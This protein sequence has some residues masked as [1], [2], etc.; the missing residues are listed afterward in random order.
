MRNLQEEVQ[1]HPSLV[2]IEG[3]TGTEREISNVPT[4]PK[5]LLGTGAVQKRKEGESGGFVDFNVAKRRSQEVM[6][7]EAS[8]EVDQGVKDWIQRKSRFESS[9]PSTIPGSYEMT[10][11]HRLHST[12]WYETSASADTGSQYTN[13]REIDLSSGRQEF[14]SRRYDPLDAPSGNRPIEPTIGDLGQML[15]Q[16]MGLMKNMVQDKT[17]SGVASEAAEQSTRKKFTETFEE[18]YGAMPSMSNP[19]RC[20]PRTSGLRP[21]KGLPGTWDEYQIHFEQIC[22]W[23]NW[24][25]TKAAEALGMSLEE[26]AAVYIH[27]LPGFRGFTIDQLCDKLAD[28]F[29]ANRTVAE[30]RMLLKMRKKQPNETYEH[31]AQDIARLANRVYSQSTYYAEQEARD[32]FLRAL[33]DEISLPIA[34]SNPKTLSDCVAHVVNLKSVLGV[35]KI[36]GRKV[37]ETEVATED[38]TAYKVSTRP[39]GSQEACYNC[40]ELGHFI[41]DCPRPKSDPKNGGGYGS[42]KFNPNQGGGKPSGSYGGNRPGPNYGRPYYG[43]RNNNNRRP[44]ICWNCEEEGHIMQNCIYMPRPVNPDTKKRMGPK[45][46]IPPVDGHYPSNA[47]MPGSTSVK[48]V[49][50]GTSEN[51]Q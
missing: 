42:N 4:Q 11:K 35:E 23:H 17:H 49:A 25:A 18:S 9:L 8:A 28:R 5:F 47:M 7:D 44:V 3:A 1:R 27:S 38:I 2:E 40:G 45:I 13:R 34:A 32:A 36:K 22:K 31:L 10:S 21:F 46:L 12:P 41:R 20:D 14:T 33:P 39:A 48:S 16:F 19:G 29:G 51:Y 15:T 6:T 24:S 26:D 50:T 43:N 37:L 30:D